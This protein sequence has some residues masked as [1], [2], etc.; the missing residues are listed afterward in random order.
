MKKIMHS[1]AVTALLFLLALVLLVIAATD[2]ETW[3]NRIVRYGVMFLT[4]LS[5]LNLASLL[6]GRLQ[7][8]SN[9]I[10]FSLLTV[11]RKFEYFSF[12]LTGIYIVRRLKDPGRIFPNI[13]SRS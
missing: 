7:G 9:N 13:R 8:Y 4:L 5:A 11:L 3:K 1:R 12:A 2:R 10:L 6:S